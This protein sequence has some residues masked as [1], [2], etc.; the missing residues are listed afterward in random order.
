M[1]TGKQLV[2]LCLFAFALITCKKEILQPGNT[3]GTPTF[4]FNGNVNGA[5][6]NLTA[7]INNY[8]MYSSYT[9]DSLNVYQFIAN[10]HPTNCNNCP[11]S[12]QFIIND[13][14]VSP[15]NT[16]IAPRINTALKPANYSF[17]TPTGGTPTS[18]AVTYTNIKAG[19]DSTSGYSYIFGDG[20]TAFTTVDTPFT[21][22]YSNPGT[23]S[24]S[25]V[26]TFNLGN[27]DTI[28]NI[29]RTANS[30]LL[31]TMSYIFS[32]D[33]STGIVVAVD[34]LLPSGPT[35]TVNWNFGDGS[36]K[37]KT[38]T[39]ASPMDSVHHKY[40]SLA[41]LHTITATATINNDTSTSIF[42]V[43]PKN[44]SI[45][46]ISILNSSVSP[47]SNPTAFSNITVIYNDASGTPYSSANIV[48]PVASAFQITT[49]SSYENNVN[50]Q[51][52]KMLHVKFNCQLKD[53]GSQTITI[54]NG[55]AVIAV[56]Y[57]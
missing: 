36:S 15:I 45:D 20:S 29:T 2:L 50:N 5:A 3:V 4:Y 51:T 6:V 40:T 52:T 37:P 47:L 39:G 26:T 43:T 31:N 32:A 53:A 11:N 35:Y 19:P 1:K 9:Q 34:S 33:T 16:S 54:N 44:P 8:Y 38:Y 46:Y 7:G 55:D 27:P 30:G 14:A 24:T 18:F 17:M 25:L 56:A 49:V 23:Y 13:A 48:Q 57:K 12:I 10:L 21:H 42:K 28:N 41:T 22:V